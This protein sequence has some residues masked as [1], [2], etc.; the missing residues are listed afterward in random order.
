MWCACGAHLVRTVCAPHAH[1][2]RTTNI[3]EA[4]IFNKETEI[5][6]K[7]Q[8]DI[9]QAKKAEVKMF[10]SAITNKQLSNT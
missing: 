6:Q 4:D 9:E 5:I 8:E 2:M 10:T 1:G 7:S 3:E